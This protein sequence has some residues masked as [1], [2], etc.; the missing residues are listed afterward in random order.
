[1]DDGHLDLLRLGYTPF[2]EQI[3]VEVGDSLAVAILVEFCDDYLVL[4]LLA[5]DEAMVDRL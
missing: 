2:V 3:L 4:G 1:M 5:F